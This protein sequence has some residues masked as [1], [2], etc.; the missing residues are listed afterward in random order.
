MISSLSEPGRSLI[1]VMIRAAISYHP[2]LMVS[3]AIDF[4]YAQAFLR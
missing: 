1:S 3:A 2:K 4:A